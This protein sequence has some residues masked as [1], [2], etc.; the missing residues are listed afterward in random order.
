MEIEMLKRQRSVVEEE[1][2][3][4]ME[5]KKIELLMVRS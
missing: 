2:K 4:L 1:R 5:R 3:L